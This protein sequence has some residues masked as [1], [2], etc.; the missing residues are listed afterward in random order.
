MVH[1]ER[2][3]PAPH[4][5]GGSASLPFPVLSS[6]RGAETQ[7]QPGTGTGGQQIRSMPQKRSS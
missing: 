3:S 1:G 7:Q 4:A 5:E 2:T 6:P